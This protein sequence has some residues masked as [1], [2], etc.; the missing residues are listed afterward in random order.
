[1]SVNFFAPA[2]SYSSSPEDG[3]AV[4][5]FKNLVK[6]LHDAG[7]AVIIDVVYNHVGVPRHLAFLDKELY[8]STDKKGEFY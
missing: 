3:S 4:L 8:F 6:A 1:M 7:M 5:E 2:S